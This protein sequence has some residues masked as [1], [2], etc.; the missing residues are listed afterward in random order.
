MVTLNN[1]FALDHPSEEVLDWCRR[2]IKS[3]SH[4]G[5]WCIP[6]SHT[7]FRFDHHNKQ[8]IQILPGFDDGAD[9]AATKRVFRHI[10]WDVVEENHGTT[11]P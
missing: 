7:T 10:G 9:F 11:E 4:N 3:S 8:L 6:R 5:I 1:D 2:L